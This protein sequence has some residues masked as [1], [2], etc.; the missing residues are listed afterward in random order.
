M[1]LRLLLLG[2]VLAGCREPQSPPEFGGQAALGYARTQ[3][4]FGPRIPGTEGHRLTAVWIDSMART[5]ADSVTVQTWTHVSHDGDSLPLRNILASF[6]PGNPKRLLF[7]A[8]WDTRPRSDADTGSRATLPIP[9]ANDG[10]SGV[11]VLLAMADAL[12]ASPPGI[13]VDLLFLDGEDYG[14][15]PDTDVLIGSTYYAK[16]QL[17]PRPE[18][19]ILLDMVG[20]TGAAF[21]KEGFSLS[22]APEVVEAIWSV[23]SQRGHGRYFIDENLGSVSDDHV[24]LQKGGIKMVDVIADFGKGYSYP[25]WHTA[26]DSIDK[27]SAD[28]LGAVGDVMM[29]MVRR[30]DR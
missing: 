14:F 15:F 2:A 10:A 4:D 25:Y 8:H 11:A 13:G 24:P 17:A 19:G 3:V 20:G 29:A 7:A 27:L 18:F 12:R 6:N 26:D 1:M 30:A 5:R 23:A 21:R 22:A 9:G 16:N 28:V